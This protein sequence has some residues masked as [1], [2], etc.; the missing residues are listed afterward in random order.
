MPKEKMKIIN[1]YW[2]SAINYYTIRCDCRNVFNYRTDR[3]TVRCPKCLKSENIETLR[4]NIKQ[5][6]IADE[7]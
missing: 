2:T 6:D 5:G 7:S 3:F 4:N 1:A